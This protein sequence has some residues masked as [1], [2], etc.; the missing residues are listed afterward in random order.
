VTLS[1]EVEGDEAEVIAGHQ[2]YPEVVKEQGR[3]G[4]H[5]RLKGPCGRGTVA[6]E[7][8]PVFGMSQRGGQ[9]VSN[10]MA[11]GPQKTIEPFIQDPIVPG[12]L[13]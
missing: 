3:K 6:Q 10:R 7:R 8:P 9:V 12:S 5:R 13:V 1:N 2:G 4:R 11:D